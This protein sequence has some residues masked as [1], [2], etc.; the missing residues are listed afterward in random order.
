ML[1]VHKTLF[2]RHSGIHFAAPY[3]ESELIASLL[4][5]RRCIE[6]KKKEGKY[7]KERRRGE[8]REE[9]RGTEREEERR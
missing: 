5:K 7:T 1:A 4:C 6:D 9:E 3:A 8:V 2:A